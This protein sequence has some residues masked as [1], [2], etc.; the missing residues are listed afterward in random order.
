MIYDRHRAIYS[1]ICAELSNVGLVISRMTAVE[2]I[3][4]IRMGIDE[5][6]TSEDWTPALPGD[7]LLPSQ[8]KQNYD[9]EE[10]DVLPTKLSQQICN[11]D[12]TIEDANIVKIGA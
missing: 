7:T 5:E 1:N 11:K 4:E 9:I 12:A 10:Y 2:G 3:R 8:R 6:Y